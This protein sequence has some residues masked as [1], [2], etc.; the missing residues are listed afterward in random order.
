ML[1]WFLYIT[2]HFKL[3]CHSLP[4]SRKL[5]NLRKGKEIK[6]IINNSIDGSC[7]NK[8]KLHLDKSE[9]VLLGKNFSQALEP[10]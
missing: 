10:N 7:L 9:T 2:T 4:W 5:E 1:E 3:K 6:F 8:S